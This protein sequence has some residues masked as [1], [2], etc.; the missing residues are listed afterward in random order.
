VTH[1]RVEFVD[2]NPVLFNPDGTSRLDFFMDDE[3]HLRP[4]AYE[5]FAKILKPVLTRALE[6]VGRT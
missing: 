1:P 3:L 4:R 5:E 2:V 6:R